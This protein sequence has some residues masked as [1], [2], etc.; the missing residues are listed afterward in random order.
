[1]RLFSTLLCGVLGAGMLFAGGSRMALA[2][3]HE[4]PAPR[5]APTDVRLPVATQAGTEAEAREYQQREQESTEVQEFA[6]GDV[7]IGVS[8]IV[9]VLIVLLL[10]L[11]LR[12]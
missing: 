8:L 4:G 5:S 7:V 6:G 1:M 10:I 2:G 3:S 11:I 12:D 9:L